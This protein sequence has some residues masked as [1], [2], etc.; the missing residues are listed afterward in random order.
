MQHAEF[1]NH[2]FKSSFSK[3][4]STNPDQ[5]PHGDKRLQQISTQVSDRAGI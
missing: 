2:T 3:E 5:R 1:K 4:Q